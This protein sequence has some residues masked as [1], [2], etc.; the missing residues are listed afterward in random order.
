M[1]T[2]SCDKTKSN[3]SNNTS[4]LL[5]PSSLACSKPSPRSFAILSA[6]QGSSP[7]LSVKPNASLPTS[8][9]PR[10][11]S[12]SLLIAN[13]HPIGSQPSHPIPLPLQGELSLTTNLH[14]GK[15][16]SQNLRSQYAANS[17][18]SQSQRSIRNILT[19][20]FSLSLSVVRLVVLVCLC[21]CLRLSVSLSFRPPGPAV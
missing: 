17:S 11:F 19:H 8:L 18:V 12:D 6:H 14:Q 13:S 3:T 20:S 7:T 5:R 2:V 4:V 10:S 16:I 1:A 21:G 9:T 15:Y